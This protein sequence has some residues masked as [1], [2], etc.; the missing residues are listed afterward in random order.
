V[1]NSAA[2]NL[3]TVDNAGNTYIAGTTTASNYIDLGEITAPASPS[4]NFCRVYAEDKGGFSVLNFVDS[5]GIASHLARDSVF[6]V[7]NNTGSTIAKGSW[8]HISGSTGTFPTIVKAQSNSLTTMPAMGIVIADITTASFGQVISAGDAVNINTSAFADG[9]ILYLSDSVAGTATTTQPTAAA[10]FS[11]RIGVVIKG[12]SVGGGIVHV[13]IG[14]EIG[15]QL[16]ADTG[17]NGSFKTGDTL[18][19]SGGEGIDTSVSGQTITIAGED[20]TSSNKGIASFTSDF[21]VTAGAVSIA[22][23]ASAT[24]ATDDKVLIK[25]TSATDAFKYVTA[26]SIAD[27]NA[28]SIFKTISVSGQS[29]VVADSTTDTLTLAAGSNITITTNAGT[30]TITIAATGGGSSDVTSS[31]FFLMGA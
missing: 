1:E 17:T 27:L 20:A 8:V 5:A 28:N 14:S 10:S 15:N 21:S 4:A 7:R 19:I 6:I 13:L 22:T 11:H 24:V 3:L 18:T 31:I 25:D 26:Q 2:T 9:D 29:D 30:D 12:G 23:P 16:A